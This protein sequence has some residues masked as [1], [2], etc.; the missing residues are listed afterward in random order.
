MIDLCP[1]TPTQTDLYRFVEDLLCTSFPP[2]EYRPLD[3]IR[4]NTLHNE[5]FVNNAIVHRGQ[6]VGL[7]SHWQLNGFCFVEH[8]AIVPDKRC[9]GYGQQTLLTFCNHSTLPIVLEV[10]LPTDEL[11]RRRIDFYR[12]CGFELWQSP[13]LQP[14]YRPGF[15]PLPMHLMVRGSLNEEQDFEQVRREIHRR[16]YGVE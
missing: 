16:V 12:R 6:A 14:P 1:L 5:A 2:V 3:E 15:E 7:L 10:E 4:H 9:G 11:S 13:Y 8:F